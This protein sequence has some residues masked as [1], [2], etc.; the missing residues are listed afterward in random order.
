MILTEEELKFVQNGGVIKLF[1]QDGRFR[2]MLGKGTTQQEQKSKYP[3]PISPE[4]TMSTSLLFKAFTRK[5]IANRKPG[6]MPL[7]DKVAD[8]LAELG[9]TSFG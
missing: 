4:N 6:D 5:Q 7:V 2:I 9:A 1:Q 8:T 3:E